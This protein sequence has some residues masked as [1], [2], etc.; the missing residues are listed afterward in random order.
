QKINVGAPW[1]DSMQGGERCM[2]LIG[3]HGP[4]RGQIDTAP[5]DCFAE[6]ADRFDLWS[7]QTEPLEFVGTG[8]SHRVV[9]KWIESGDQPRALCRGAR[10]RKLLAAHDRAQAGKAF[11]PA[12]QT[13][14]AS[15][16]CDRLY[17]A[18]PHTTTRH[19]RLT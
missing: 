6:L 17:G 3:L 16:F 19:S 14:S 4:D 13:K 2:G 9:V 5:G 11:L 7:R 18:V 15:P 1:S 10:G 12:A 8:Q